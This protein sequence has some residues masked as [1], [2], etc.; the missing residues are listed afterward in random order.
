MNKVLVSNKMLVK[1][2]LILLKRKLI[3]GQRNSVFK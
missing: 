2:L 3:D 1:K